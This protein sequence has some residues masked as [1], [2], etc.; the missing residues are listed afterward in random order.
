MRPDKTKRINRY[1]VRAKFSHHVILGGD[2]M[3]NAAGIIRVAV[4]SAVCAAVMLFDLY[5][6]SGLY[7]KPRANAD[8]E[9][10]KTQSVTETVTTSGESTENGKENAS[11][12]VAAAAE[13]AAVGK[14]LNKFISPYT[15]NTCYNNVYLKNSTNLP[16]DIKGMLSEPL[17]FKIEKSEE[18]QV[19]IVHSHATESFLTE[20]R[21][22]YTAADATRSRDNNLN[23]VALGKIIA[24]KLNAAGIKTLH[25][26]NQHDYPD[27]NY[28]Y[29]NAAKTIKAALKEHPSIKI[30]IDLHRDAVGAPGGDKVKVTTKINGK[31]AAQIMLVMGSQS[32]DT[33]DF[34]DYRENLKLAVRFQQTLEVMYPSLARSISLVSNNYNESLTKGSMLLEVGTDANS[35]E[36]VKYSAELAAN[37]LISLLNTLT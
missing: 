35:L 27:Y 28:S 34:P 23:T 1:F 36:E 14:I 16:V 21:D 9:K 31:S 12:A 37:A 24:D 32:G 11:S 3:K 17:T 5:I 18:P 2:G 19:L 10:G 6:F 13:S 20:T 29:T 25:S 8:A 30:V 33:T 4:S 26:E 15:A 7:G 22:Y